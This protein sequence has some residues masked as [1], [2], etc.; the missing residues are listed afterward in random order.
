MSDLSSLANTSVVNYVSFCLIFFVL[1]Y[2]YFTDDKFLWIIVFFIVA[3]ML[4][5]IN[6]LYL[7]S[8]P[9]FCGGVQVNISLYA[10]LMPWIIIFGSFAICLIVFPG[11]LRAF[12]NTF[13]I[14]AAQM[15]GIDEVIDKLFDSKNKAELALKAKERND[16]DLLKAID[17]VYTGKL[18]FINELTYDDV[19]ISKKT[20]EDGSLDMGPDG[21]PQ[22]SVK[23]PSLDNLTP[24]GL[25]KE[26]LSDEHKKNLYDKIL[27]KDTVGHFIWY[28]LVGSLTVLVSTNTLLNSGCDTKSGDYNAIFNS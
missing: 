26:N 7:T 8:L 19:E 5:F 13:G 11:W 28:V 3:C 6:N 17:S 16:I 4:Q 10:T 15:F 24:A 14:K 21:K 1:K 2:K 20:K 22:I 23:W 9:L 27:L 18:L 12:S 25:S